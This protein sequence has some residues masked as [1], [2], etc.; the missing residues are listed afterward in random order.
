[1]ND[2][3]ESMLLFIG[4][5]SIV[6][7]ILSILHLYFGL[8]AEGGFFIGVILTLIGFFGSLYYDDNSKQKG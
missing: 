7:G 2:R 6:I 4:M 5:F 3:T 1:M 8:T